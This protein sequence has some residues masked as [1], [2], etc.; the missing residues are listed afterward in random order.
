MRTSICTQEKLR[1]NKPSMLG[2]TKS[3]PAVLSQ[4]AKL[5]VLVL[6][7]ISLPSS[8]KVSNTLLVPDLPMVIIS[9]VDMVVDQILI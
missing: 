3:T 1:L 7:D 5:D 4:V 2:M 6:S 9:P 8:G